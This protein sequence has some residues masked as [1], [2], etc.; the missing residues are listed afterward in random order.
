MFT[1]S[2]SVSFMLLNLYRTLLTLCLSYWHNSSARLPSLPTYKKTAIWK[3]LSGVVNHIEAFN[4]GTNCFD[5]TQFMDSTILTIIQ[6][7]TIGWV[8]PELLIKH[9]H[10]N[11]F[12]SDR[13]RETAW[14]SMSDL[15]KDTIRWKFQSLYNLSMFHISCH[16]V[17]AK[18]QRQ[19]P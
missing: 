12:S 19:K 14:C 2:K 16:M 8:R 18:I 10:M 17:A 11:V 5:N 6:S 7:K 3:S 13:V 9:G 4:F 15:S 1:R